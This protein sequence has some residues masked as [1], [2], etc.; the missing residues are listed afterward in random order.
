MI[1]LLFILCFSI[2]AA[3]TLGFTLFTFLLSRK[4]VTHTRGA[5]LPDVTL[6]VCAYNEAEVIAKKVE[7]IARTD[8]P[9]ERL[10]VLFINDHS[11][12]ATRT[13]LERTIG[14]LPFRAEVLDNEYERSKPNALNFAFSRIDTELIVETDADSLL[15]RDAVRE[16]VG[17]FADPRVGGANGE[18]RILSINEKGQM[19]TDEQIYRRFYSIWRKGESRLH[20]ISICNGPIVAF[21]TDLVR[22][23][24]LNSLADDT[25]LLFHIIA[26]GFRFVYDDRAVAYECTP[27]T[28]SERFKQKIRR[29]KGVLQVYSRHLPLLVN[30]RYDWRIFLPALLQFMAVPYCVLAGTVLYGVLI[31]QSLWWALPLVLLLYPPFF[32]V[33]KNVWITHVIMA[34]APFYVRSKWDVMSSSRDMLKQIDLENK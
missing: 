31:A 6:L 15:E 30:G 3:V 32:A 2:T 13:I 17:N 10:R 21:R 7:N 34:A 24:H 20:S 11:T 28:L 25:E 16:L 33:M 8:Y 5:D 4:A 23:V 19:E 12:D 14:S 26:K 9:P 22:D 29:C 18:V 27:T 1:A